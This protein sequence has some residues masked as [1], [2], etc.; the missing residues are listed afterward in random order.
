MIQLPSWIFLEDLFNPGIF[1]P[2]IVGRHGLTNGGR[3][4]SKL[5]HHTCMVSMAPIDFDTLLE[6]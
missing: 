6:I 3:I 1:V 5:F 4:F 2:G